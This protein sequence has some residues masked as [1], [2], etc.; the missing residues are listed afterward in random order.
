MDYL[1][2]KRKAGNIIYRDT[3]KFKPSAKVEKRKSRHY[4]KR[5]FVACGVK[6][7]SVECRDFKPENVKNR[8]CHNKAGDAQ[9]E[10]KDNFLFA[11]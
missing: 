8:A 6:H 7:F 9:N 11:F 5:I 4:Q 2:Q 10:Q 3:F 1:D